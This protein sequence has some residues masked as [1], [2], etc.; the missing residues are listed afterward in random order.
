[1]WAWYQ[2][3]GL[4]DVAAYLM[5]RDISSFDAK[6]P[7]PKTS[8][9]WS[10]ADS[11]RAPEEAELADVLVPLHSDSDRLTV[12]WF[13]CGQVGPINQDSDTPRDPRAP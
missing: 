3:G 2:N 8:A 6:A 5:Q 9:F 10:I 13:Q 11:N 4:R 7:P 12:P 1:M